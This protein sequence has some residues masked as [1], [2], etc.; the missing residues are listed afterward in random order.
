MKKIKTI[1]K[2]TTNMLSIIGA[3]ITGINQVEG[4]SIPYAVQIVGV[5]S[6]VQG[7]IGAYLLKNKAT[8]RRFNYE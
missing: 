6:V 3:I 5:I 8:K 4:V 7:V 2:Y 1:A